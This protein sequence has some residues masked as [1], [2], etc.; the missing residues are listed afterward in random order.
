M[1]RDVNCDWSTMNLV[2]GSAVSFRQQQRRHTWKKIVKSV[3]WHLK[4]AK[5]KCMQYKNL[6]SWANWINNLK[7]WTR[8]FFVTSTRFLF[9]ISST[10]AVVV[11]F[12]SIHCNILKQSG[13]VCC[14]EFCWNKKIEI[15]V[16]KKSRFVWSKI[17]VVL[18]LHSQVSGG[19][20]K[21][22]GRASKTP[23]DS[24]L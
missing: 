20:T 3:H 16:L 12:N 8:C 5:V 13:A 19:K 11:F 7:S 6:L 2:L 9:Y 15:K 10:T 4:I 21:M 17:M 18:V 24:L 22:R 1:R 23:W 14:L